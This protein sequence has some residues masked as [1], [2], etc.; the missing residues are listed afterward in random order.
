MSQWQTGDSF[1]ASAALAHDFLQGWSNQEDNNS[2]AT[3][4]C[5]GPQSQPVKASSFHFDASQF[6]QPQLN[7]TPLAARFEAQPREEAPLAARLEITHNDRPESVLR[8]DAKEALS[9]GKDNQTPLSRIYDILDVHSQ[10]SRWLDKRGYLEPFK[11]P[12][13]TLDLNFGT[14]ARGSK[15]GA[16]MTAP[17]GTRRTVVACEGGI[18]FQRLTG[19][20][21]QEL[22]KFLSSGQIVEL[23]PNRAI[24]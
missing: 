11:S 10:S 9:G 5:W 13:C 1:R 12:D 14:D 18:T 19:A 4:E 16:V 17:D 3:F 6:G 2:R 24:A 23:N 7:E 20:N 21:G 22:V 15:V 8:N